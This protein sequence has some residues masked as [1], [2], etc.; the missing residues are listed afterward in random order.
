MRPIGHQ[1]S[2]TGVR[3]AFFHGGPQAG[4]LV[5]LIRADDRLVG[6]FG[7]LKQ[8]AAQWDGKTAYWQLPG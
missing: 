7:L 5:E 1:L 6:F 2:E 4:G 3:V 8:A